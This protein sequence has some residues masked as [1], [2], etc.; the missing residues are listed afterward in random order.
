MS[1][2]NGDKIQDGEPL[3]NYPDGFGRLDWILEQAIPH[4][5]K[6][7]LVCLHSP[8]DIKTGQCFPSIATLA[9]R[10]GLS[11][12]TVKTGI[13]W[14]KAHDYL[15]IQY[16]FNTKGDQTTS[17]YSL[18]KPGTQAHAPDNAVL[19]TVGVGQ[20][21][22][23]GRS[24]VEGGVGQPLTP[25]SLTVTPQEIPQGIPQGMHKAR[26]SSSHSLNGSTCRRCGGP[27]TEDWLMG[28]LGSGW[29]TACPD[30]AKSCPRIASLD[31][32]R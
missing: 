18:T 31:A 25:E 22:T 3:A 20:L 13:Q 10:S 8:A 11:R 1:T 19:E 9:R 23:G 2:M 16:R 6:M 24:V 28:E 4:A 7:L 32:R 26:A 17:L 30:D 21:L 27:F 15:T 5:R 29:H 12:G 14:L